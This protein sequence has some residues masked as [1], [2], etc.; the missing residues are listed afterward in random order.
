MRTLLVGLAVQ[1]LKGG[2]QVSNNPKKKKRV[3]DGKHIN[4]GKKNKIPF[5]TKSWYDF[6]KW[7]FR[8]LKEAIF[9]KTTMRF[10]FSLL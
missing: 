8:L 6:R 3:T 10:L 2:S 1:K 7:Y 5:I 9:Y 4:I